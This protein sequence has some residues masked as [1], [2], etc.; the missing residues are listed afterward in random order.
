MELDKIY[1]TP[2]KVST[3]TCNA[4][5]GTDIFIDLSILY[6]N[7]IPLSENNNIIW[8]QNSSELSKGIN[9]KKIRKSKKDKKKKNRFDNQITILY[10]FN[11][12]YRPNIKIFKNGNIQLTG[13]NKLNGDVEIIANYIINI[14]KNI[15]NIDNKINNNYENETKDEFFN[16]LKYN[17]FKI[18]MI[19][20]DFKTFIDPEF[21]NKFCIKRKEIHNLLISDKYKNKS[22]FQPGIYQGVKLEYYYNPYN[23]TG[24]CQCYIHNFNKKNNMSNCKKVTIAIF[25]SGSVLIT[26]GINV[27]QIEKAYLYITQVI[28]DNIKIIQKKG[29][30]LLD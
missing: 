20:S 18:R 9:P 17:N 4:N 27:D 24:N 12:N 28:K 23:S 2:Y 1:F 25:E 13:I 29:I 7:I 10:Q 8:I 21:K 26:G 30:N 15:Y 3:I 5:I 14:I 11:I 22:S 6:D 16:K 19:N